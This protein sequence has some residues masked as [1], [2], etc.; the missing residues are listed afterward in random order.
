MGTQQ[1]HIAVH[2]F[3]RIVFHNGH[4]RFLQTAAAVP[5]PHEVQ[6]RR[7]EGIVHDAV[8]LRVGEIR[9]A[10]VVSLLVRS[11]FPN[12]TQHQSLRIDLFHPVIEQLQKF[13]RQFVR[14]IQPEA[15]RT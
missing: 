6:D 2:H 8:Q 1:V 9:P 11:I 12:L 10:A 3:R 4:H 13:V 14:H 5:S 7:A 15:I